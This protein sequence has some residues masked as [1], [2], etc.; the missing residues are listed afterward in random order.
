[1]SA[2][3]SDGEIV[4]ELVSDMVGDRSFHRASDSLIKFGHALR[5][6]GVWRLLEALCLSYDLYQ[7]NSTDEEL[8]GRKRLAET[9]AGMVAVHSESHWFIHPTTALALAFHPSTRR[10]FITIVA[11]HR[12]VSSDHLFQATPAATVCA[13]SAKSY[14][15]LAGGRLECLCLRDIYW[16]RDFDEHVTL[17][18][19]NGLAP[20]V[21][22]WHGANELQL[23]HYSLCIAR[24]KVPFLST[25]ARIIQHKLYAP[26]RVTRCG[27]FLDADP[28]CETETPLSDAMTV[29]R[30]IKFKVCPRSCL[31]F[32]MAGERTDAVSDVEIWLLVEQYIGGMAPLD[33]TTFVKYCI[34][35]WLVPRV[36]S[37]LLAMRKLERVEACR[38]RIALARIAKKTK[39]E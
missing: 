20:Y 27:K 15:P 16:G 37:R 2:D 33:L 3:I 19:E 34:I 9:L 36:P 35:E 31:H 21:A 4:A 17:F 22:T 8:M 32:G 38:Q 18:L 1:M 28:Q 13:T 26:Q 11:K 12:S 10:A 7:Y 25:V 30:Y 14:R 23:R 39:N 5:D 24:P 29:A 6:A